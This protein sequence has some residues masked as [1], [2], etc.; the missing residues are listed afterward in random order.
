M[1]SFIF[2]IYLQIYG[3]RIK[4]FQTFL[5]LMKNQCFQHHNVKDH[6]EAIVVVLL[7][8]CIL[9]SLWEGKVAKKTSQLAIFNAVNL[10]IY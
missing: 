4:I 2:I 1:G 5:L 7:L 10:S 3:L 8:T 6:E 9:G